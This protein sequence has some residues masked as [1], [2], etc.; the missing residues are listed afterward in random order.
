MGTISKHDNLLIER[1]TT[2]LFQYFFY[3]KSNIDSENFSKR[4]ALA[5]ENDTPSSSYKTHPKH[6]KRAQLSSSHEAITSSP[7]HTTRQK[8]TQIQEA[9]QPPI[10]RQ[11]SWA[12]TSESSVPHKKKLLPILK[13]QKS[14][15]VL[16]TSEPYFVSHFEPHD[17]DMSFRKDVVQTEDT[18]LEGEKNGAGFFLFLFFDWGGGGVIFLFW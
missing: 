15:N 14:D 3:R 1:K 16:R 13:D 17:E 5:D 11:K 4:L 2:L 6:R 12:I 10:P 18:Q 9:I 8:T 7:T